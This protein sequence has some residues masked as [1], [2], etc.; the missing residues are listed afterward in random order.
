MKFY[1]IAKE[2]I[3][4]QILFHQNEIVMDPKSAIRMDI[5]LA[6]SLFWF[7]SF[8]PPLDDFHHSPTLWK[9]EEGDRI[10]QKE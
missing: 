8:L 1:E 6:Y 9:M 5:R 4:S 2:K 7:S 3:L 10:L